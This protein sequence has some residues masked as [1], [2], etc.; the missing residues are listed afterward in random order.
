VR[1]PDLKLGPCAGGLAD[2]MSAPSVRG[3]GAAKALRRPA[4]IIRM[5]T[6]EV[7]RREQRKRMRGLLALVVVLAIVATREHFVGL[8]NALA[9][10][11]PRLKPNSV[12]LRLLRLINDARGR[13]G[14]HPLVFSSPLMHAAYFH[15][16]DMARADY[17]AYDGPGEDTPVDRIT[18]QGVAYREVAENLYG[19]TTDR[20][21]KLADL[22]L[23]HWL[24]DPLDRNN[25]LSPR[26]RMTAIAIAHGSDGS[27]RITQDFAR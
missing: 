8:E 6:P 25:L 10:A 9:T 4:K 1:W 14:L 13:A 24:S 18:A 22:A 23:E 11:R 15:S 27:F 20:V 19:G 7:V 17:I 3:R 16:A 2:R 21:A 26:F 12:E 5:P